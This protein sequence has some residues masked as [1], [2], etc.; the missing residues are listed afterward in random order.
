QNSFLESLGFKADT[1]VTDFT[2]HSKVRHSKAESP[3]DETQKTSNSVESMMLEK[4]EQRCYGTK[5]YRGVRRR[6][7]RKFAAE[8]R[9]PTSKGSRV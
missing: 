9:D 5:R 1:K 8:I 4:M 6:P 7:W 3:F 2:S